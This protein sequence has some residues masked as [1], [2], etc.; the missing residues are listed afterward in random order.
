MAR[1]QCTICAR[2]FSGMSTFDAHHD[3]DYERHPAVKC[4][5]PEKLGMRHHKTMKGKN[6]EPVWTFGGTPDIADKNEE[7]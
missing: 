5:N 7:D 3:V 6:G 1:S 4:I 2:F